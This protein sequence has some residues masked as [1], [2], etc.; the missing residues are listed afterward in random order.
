M[1]WT[2]MLNDFTSTNEYTPI[3]EQTAIN[4]LVDYTPETLMITC[5]A[6]N[7]LGSGEYTI[8]LGGY[9][10]CNGT[11]GIPLG[12]SSP[13]IMSGLQTATDATTGE[14]VFG[15]WR[16]ISLRD[17]VS[18]PAL[19]C[20][21]LSTVTQ[22]VAI[23]STSANFQA[24]SQDYMIFGH[25]AI[26]Y[27]GLGYG[28]NLPSAPNSEVSP[29]GM[30]FNTLTSIASVYFTDTL[31][32]NPPQAWVETDSG[33]AAAIHPNTLTDAVYD[34]RMDRIVAVGNASE[35]GGGQTSV[36]IWI[37]M[38]DDATAPT[39]AYNGNIAGTTGTPVYPCYYRSVDIVSAEA[40]LPTIFM[41][42]GATYAWPN[43]DPP[44]TGIL[45]LY[46]A[47]Y[48]KAWGGGN[49]RIA[50]LD[51]GQLNPAGLWETLF[52]GVLEDMPT[53]ITMVQRVVAD[54]EDVIF[55][56]GSNGLGPFLYS[57]S[58][59]TTQGGTN[60]IEPIGSSTKV[61]FAEQKVDSG[62]LISTVEQI[63]TYTTG[64]LTAPLSVVGFTGRKAK[65]MSGGLVYRSYIYPRTPPAYSPT[66]GSDNGF[67]I[68]LSRGA[69]L[70]NFTI[71]Q[72]APSTQLS[73]LRIGYLENDGTG[74]PDV[75]YLINSEYGLGATPATNFATGA[76]ATNNIARCYFEYILYDGVDALV[77]KKLQQLG[78][79]VTITNTEWYKQT[80]LGQGLDVDADFFRE[81][82]DLQDEQNANRQKLAEKYGAKRPAKR[83]VR[84][85]LFDEYAHMEE[86]MQEMDAMRENEADFEVPWSDEIG[87]M[88]EARIR[89]K[90]TQDVVRINE[91]VESGEL[92][93]LGEVEVEENEKQTEK[94]E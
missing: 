49:P 9:Y 20:P 24:K 52:V 42:G 91:L 58:G 13:V 61:E 39:F 68:S 71:N 60:L 50:G 8:C 32:T 80:I 73:N 12:D 18:N 77:A 76:F 65:L 53:N 28:A 34:A 66:F 25:T 23:P 93:D 48:D 17:V 84:T 43:P 35:G 38:L 78:I 82:S 81:W 94:D 10:I 74:N 19:T 14:P 62:S 6:M 63:P 51:N 75:C 41:A 92:A 69:N 7:T 4:N 5:A 67:L 88:R 1:G 31:A 21:E 40:G 56:G 70:W 55:V 2:T 83:P 89:E 59:L 47:N 64:V 30:L 46:Q 22:I 15:M 37:E 33:A 87:D 3:L 11:S 29:F 45:T 44:A 86:L 16:A 54:G 26:D 90:T 36:G 79:R 85:E 57:I 72:D 27:T